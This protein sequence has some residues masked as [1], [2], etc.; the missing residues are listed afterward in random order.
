MLTVVCV[1][2]WINSCHQLI[3][4]LSANHSSQR[5]T[6][7]NSFSPENKMM[8]IVSHE[9]QV[10]SVM[11]FA[12]SHTIS[13]WQKPGHLGSHRHPLNCLVIRRITWCH[14]KVWAL[15]PYCTLS[16]LILPATIWNRLY[17]H[18]PHSTD[19]KIEVQPVKGT[20]MAQRRELG[21][22]VLLL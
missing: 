13:K 22:G 5:S 16:H 8:S 17:Y 1:S 4:N 14:M 18:N 15:S 9:M 21:T 6:N 7:I 20:E 10:Q 11:K 2:L 12:Q 3:T 19:E